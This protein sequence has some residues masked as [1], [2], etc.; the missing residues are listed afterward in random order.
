MKRRSVGGLI[1]P[2]VL[3]ARAAGTGEKPGEIESI[4]YVDLEVCVAA[5]V[6][7]LL[8]LKA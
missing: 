5:V 6:G 7:F 8:Y 4:W 1:W 2:C 3:G